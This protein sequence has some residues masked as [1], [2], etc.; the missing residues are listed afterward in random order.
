MFDGDVLASDGPCVSLGDG[1]VPSADDLQ[2]LVKRV[3]D[4]RIVLFAEAFH[5][6]GQELELR[7][8]LFFAL[9]EQGFSAIAIESG[10]IESHIVHDYVKG[11]QG[12]LAAAVR[13][14]IS[15]G[16]DVHPANLDLVARM[17]SYNDG[18]GNAPINFYGFDVSGMLSSTQPHFSY[19]GLT[20]KLAA[21]LEAMDETDAPEIARAL[22][23]LASLEFHPRRRQGA[24]YYPDISQAERDRCTAVIARA[25][26]WLDAHPDLCPT[27]AAAADR[28]WARRTGVALQQLDAWMRTI[29][30]GYAPDPDPEAP[31][32]YNDAFAEGSDVRDRAM[33]DNI[34]WILDREGP[35]A[36]LMVFASRYH[37]NTAP[38][39]VARWGREGRGF[40]QA[41]AGHYLRQRFGTEIVAIGDL[42]A[43]EDSGGHALDTRL[44]EAAPP[45][46]L[47]DLKHVPP[48]GWPDAVQ[49]VGGDLHSLEFRPRDAFDLLVH[50]GRAED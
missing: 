40:T 1:P 8:N 12:E 19:A 7:N 15:W 36:R 27:D 45:P 23:G 17:R 2:P 33:A 26:R 22:G 47:I 14:G 46:F 31:F 29:P 24:I 37:L 34:G 9:V 28:A 11:G 18:R 10:L 38:S 16:F 50:L 4:A 44:E 39:H 6:R 42:I 21:F 41:S 5:L 43:V 30:L 49:R 32:E 20:K 13:H 3:R 25:N 35:D 48:G